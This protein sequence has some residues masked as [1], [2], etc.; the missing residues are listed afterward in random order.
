MNDKNMDFIVQSLE[1]EIDSDEIIEFKETLD[2]GFK[3]LIGI[4]ISDVHC[5]DTAILEVVKVKGMDI[6]P[7]KFEAAH[8]MSSKNVAPNKRFFSWFKPVQISGD[9]MV[10]RFRDPDYAANYVLQVQVLLCNNP[11]IIQNVLFA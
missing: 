11:E 4:A 1:H 7:E 3:Y 6:L 10:I 9:E 8:L 2:Y 5:P